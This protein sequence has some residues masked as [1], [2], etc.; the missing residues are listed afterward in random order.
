[1]ARQGANATGSPSWRVAV[2]D[3][4]LENTSASPFLLSG[5][6][7]RGCLALPATERLA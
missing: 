3:L 2:P 4:F 7:R 6:L 5:P 1:M